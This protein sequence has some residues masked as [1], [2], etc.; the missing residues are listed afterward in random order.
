MIRFQRTGLPAF[1]RAALYGVPLAFA[2]SLSSQATAEVVSAAENGF[3]IRHTLQLAAPADKVY[4]ALVKPERWWSPSHTF[5]GSASNLK[6]DP[7]AGGCF[8]EQL[9]NGGSVQHLNVVMVQPGK[10]LR[11]R[12]ALGPFQGTGTEG[13]LSIALKESGQQTELTLTY[14]MGGYLK[15]GFTEWSKRVDAMLGEQVGR[16]KKFVDTSS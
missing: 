2:C 7:K 10:L 9:P 11:M 1:L 15:D 8:C 12:G 14:S 6:L 16:L 13:A 3:E 5:S 4:A